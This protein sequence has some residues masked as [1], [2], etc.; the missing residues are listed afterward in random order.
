MTLTERHKKY[1]GEKLKGLLFQ[2]EEWENCVFNITVRDKSGVVGRIS[3]SWDKDAKWKV[4][5]TSFACPKEFATCY[6]ARHA[7]ADAY[8]AQK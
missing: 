7:F 3:Q 6:K 5:D 8:A 4:S 1:G 2:K